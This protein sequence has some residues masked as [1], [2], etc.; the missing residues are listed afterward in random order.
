M[1]RITS[2]DSGQDR[3]LQLEGKICQQWI[4]EL[5]KQ[6]HSSLTEGNRIVLDFS[7]VIYIDEEAVEMLSRFSSEQL[8]KKNCS[9]YIRTLFDQQRRP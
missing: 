4:G 9:L 1:L 3:V 5:C 8:E 7:K 6:I 2:S